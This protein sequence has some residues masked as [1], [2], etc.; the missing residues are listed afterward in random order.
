[1]H[2]IRAARGIHAFLEGPRTLPRLHAFEEIH[3]RGIQADA[4]YDVI[5]REEPGCV[6]V[7]RRT[8]IS[9]V[10]TTYDEATAV[11]QA[12]RCLECHVQTIY[13]GSLCIAC[14]RC[15][16][17]CPHSCLSFVPLEDV[18]ARG[19]DPLALAAAGDASNGPVSVL[20]KDESVC[21]RC[22]LCAERC[23]TGAMTMERYAMSVAESPA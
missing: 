3:P 15:V 10:E 17:V 7:E 20:I 16:D 11:E 8:G 9:E 22:G 5:P 13:D 23:P 4:T 18:D 2:R 14:G 6:A 19:A 1:M 12:S 21:V